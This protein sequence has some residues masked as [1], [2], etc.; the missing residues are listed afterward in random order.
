MWELSPTG[1]LIP[2]TESMIIHAL[3]SQPARD[4]ILTVE[5]I[6]TNYP[7]AAS[8]DDGRITAAGSKPTWPPAGKTAQIVPHSNPVGKGEIGDNHFI[9]RSYL[10][11]DTSGVGAGATIL[12]A[13]LRL[14]L[15][16]NYAIASFGIDVRTK[17]WGA[18]LAIGDWDGTG[19]IRGSV[20][21]ASL[22]PGGEWV[23]IDIDPAAIEKEAWTEFELMSDDEAGAPTG[24]HFDGFQSWDYPP[25]GGSA[26]EIVI[27]LQGG[28]PGSTAFENY[29]VGA[30]ITITAAAG[31]DSVVNIVRIDGVP[32]AGPSEESLV[33]EEATT[34]PAI[35]RTLAVD[36]PYQ[37]TRA[38]DMVT[39]AERLAE[40]HSGLVRRLRMALQE[41]DAASLAQM[42]A[43]ELDD[44]IR[45]INTKWDFSTKL[46]DYFFIEGMEWTVKDQGKVLE[47][48]FDL[49]EK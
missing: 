48:T 46:D 39:E 34:P 29:G 8:G 44:L 41:E 21:V 49:E 5:G 7:I 6:G 9:Y 25:E 26:P 40:R 22:P 30:K 4:C 20:E 24:K 14:K 18:T 17:A 16:Y 31:E 19:D 33:V 32:L 13:K 1:F 35:P 3:Y 15:Y 45:V 28:G 23:E 47:V 12:S 2:A 37:G 27:E 42:Q 36:M 38:P 43:R 10:R 11:F